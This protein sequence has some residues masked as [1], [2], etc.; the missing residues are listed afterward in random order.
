MKIL[1]IIL[2]LALFLIVCMSVTRNIEKFEYNLNEHQTCT[3]NN[4][5]KEN[6]NDKNDDTDKNDDDKNNDDKNEDDDKSC[7]LVAQDGDIKYLEH[8]AC[9]TNKKLKKIK[10]NRPININVTYNVENED[11]KEETPLLQNKTESVQ[12][13]PVIKYIRER[14]PVDYVTGT[15]SNNFITTGHGAKSS[16]GSGPVRLEFTDSYSVPDRNYV[17]HPYYKRRGIGFGSTDNAK[18]SDE[19]MSIYTDNNP[20]CYTLLKEKYYSFPQ[21]RYSVTDLANMGVS[22]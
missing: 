18:I 15:V 16:L 5:E 3:K 12:T 6:D 13:K 19:A 21:E 1:S 17:T 20:D 4:N 11:I 2:L 9:D 10:Y 14:C 8:P 22:K 7:K